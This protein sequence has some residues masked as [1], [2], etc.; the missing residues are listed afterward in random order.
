[1]EAAIFTGV[2][3]F[4][5]LALAWTH[6]RKARRRSTLHQDS[7]GHW[8]WTD[9]DGR[10]RCSRIHPDAPGGAW[11]QDNTSHDG[12]GFDGD[13]GGGDGGGGD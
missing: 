13:G 11:Y 6:R 8:V 7:S 9:F 3:F 2:F 10:E 5:I 12:G 1:M 4:G